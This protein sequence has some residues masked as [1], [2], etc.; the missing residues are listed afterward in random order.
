MYVDLN[1]V[2]DSLKQRGVMKLDVTVEDEHGEAVV[3]FSHDFRWKDKD[4]MMDELSAKFEDWT[5]MLYVQLEEAE[6]N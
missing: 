1:A 3:M 4:E 5:S 2:A 6:E